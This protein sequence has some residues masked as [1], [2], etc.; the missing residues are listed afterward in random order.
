MHER[1]AQ[2]QRGRRGNAPRIF[3]ALAGLAA[4]MLAAWLGQ[5]LSNT[6]HGGDPGGAMVL[7][8]SWQPAFCEGR[9]R[10]P[11]CRALGPGD[12]AA[13]SFSLHGLWPGGRDTAY[14]GTAA[15]LE[16]RRWSDLPEPDL[17]RATRAALA[18]AMP[19]ARS[20]LHRHQWAKHGSC[21]G[22]GADTYFDDALALAA[23]ANASIL[24]EAFRRRTGAR[25]SAEEIRAGADQ[26]FGEG[27]GARIAVV[28]RDD[29]IVELRFHLVGRVGPE[30]GLGPLLRAARP[31]AP[32]CTGGRVD[33]V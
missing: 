21:Y 28:C 27:A 7:A 6:G 31:V 32:G 4:V 18:R 29:M 19:G 2:S 13:R 30:G 24:V 11:E 17:D 20:L 14:C 10:R 26:A 12:R 25:L 33:P 22:S 16:G 8:L 1:R 23:E 9:P 15:A 3:G 5:P